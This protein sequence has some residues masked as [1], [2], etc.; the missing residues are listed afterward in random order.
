MTSEVMKNDLEICEG[1][2]GV[3]IRVIEPSESFSSNA[4]SFAPNEILKG[5]EHGREL[6]SNL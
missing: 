2:E 6:A 5:Y 4:L 1:V 3:K